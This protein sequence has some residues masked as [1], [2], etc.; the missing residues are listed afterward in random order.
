MDV[1]CGKFL[2]HGP[3]VEVLMSV[4][5]R[6]DERDWNRP[7]SANDMRNAERYFKNLKVSVNYRQLKRS[8][9]VTGLSRDPVSR[10]SFRDSTMK[11][12]DFNYFLDNGRDKS[13][14]AYFREQ[15]Q[16]EF[17]YPGLPCLLAG[18]SK[19]PIQLPIELCVLI[20]GNFELF[21]S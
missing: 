7:L 13:V 1:T 6:K 18:T 8:Y 14:A 9:K 16:I 21:T 20:P 12:N 4:L 15:Y 2:Q 10:L 17:K 19:K 11:L 5:E 3:C